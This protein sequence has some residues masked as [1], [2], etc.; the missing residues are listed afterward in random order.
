M[1]NVTTKKLCYVGMPH[2]YPD[3]IPGELYE[4]YRELK[5]HY[6]LKYENTLYDKSQFFVYDKNSLDDFDM[7]H[8]EEFYGDWT[9]PEL[10]EKYCGLRMRRLSPL[11]TEDRIKEVELN[12]IQWMGFD[13][14]DRLTGENCICC[15]GK[16]FHGADLN[17]PG[18]L[19]DGSTTYSGRRYRSMDGKHRIQ[20]M[21]A[22]GYTSFKFY[23]FHLDEIKD[24]YSDYPN[25]INYLPEDEDDYE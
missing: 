2:V 6:V 9:I 21:I 11:L 5:N 14:P 10:P 13:L 16:R 19:L 1:K 8:W 12:N 18:L 24:Y 17:R 3:L 4:M 20:K 7:C 15:E 23:V 22:E 25:M